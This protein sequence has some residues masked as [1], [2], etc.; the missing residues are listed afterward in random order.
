MTEWIATVHLLLRGDASWSS[1]QFH[2]HVFDDQG[3]FDVPTWHDV[4]NRNL[5]PVIVIQ[6]VQMRTFDRFKTMI[7]RRASVFPIN[8]ISDTDIWHACEAARL[9]Y[10]HGEPYIALREL[11]AYLIVRKL[12]RMGKSGGTALN[13]NF[14]WKDDIPK[15]GF[16][17]P[18]CDDRTIFDVVDAL[19]NVGVVVRKESMGEWKYALGDRS[20]IDQILQAKSFEHVPKLKKFFERSKTPVSAKLLDFNDT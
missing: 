13:K 7:Q 5:G 8:P 16:P 17:K 12:D 15:G 10:D 18:P 3:N 1:C 19:F 2:T 20:V 11:T 9:A 4:V 14:L 6:K